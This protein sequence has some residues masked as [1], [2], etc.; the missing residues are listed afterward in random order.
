MTWPLVIIDEASMN[1]SYKSRIVFTKSPD[2]AIPVSP[3]YRHTSQRIRTPNNRRAAPRDSLRTEHAS[4]VP[5]HQTGTSGVLRSSFTANVLGSYAPTPSTIGE[6]PQETACTPKTP[7]T[8]SPTHQGTVRVAKDRCTA[9]ASRRYTLR[10]RRSIHNNTPIAAS[11]THQGRA[12]LSKDRCTANSSRCDTL[13]QSSG[14]AI[15]HT[16]HTHPL[17]CS[18]KHRRPKRVQQSLGYGKAHTRKPAEEDGSLE[19]TTTNA[20]KPRRIERKA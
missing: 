12:G 5:P 8:A 1:M 15:R 13:E 11:P 19:I 18:S 6:L 14:T 7:I 4:A 10:R 16:Q 20:M 9:N 3:R 17:C 2:A